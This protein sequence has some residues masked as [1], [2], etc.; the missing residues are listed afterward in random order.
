MIR[1]RARGAGLDAEICRH[2]LPRY[3]DCSLSESGG[4]LENAQA[5]AAPES[6]G[7]TKLYDGARNE[8]TLDEIERMTI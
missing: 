5:V 8:T 4:A 6:P 2:A 1:R 3:R 7:A